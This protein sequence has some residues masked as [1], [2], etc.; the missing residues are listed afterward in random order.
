MFQLWQSQ[1]RNVSLQQNIRLLSVT[2]FSYMSLIPL[3]PVGP[4]GDRGLTGMNG[5]KGASGPSGPQGN[6]CI[7]YHCYYCFFRFMSVQT[8]N[9]YTF[10]SWC[11]CKW[12]TC[13][14]CACVPVCIYDCVAIQLLIKDILP[15]NAISYVTSH[16]P[17]HYTDTRLTSTVT[18]CIKWI[19]QPIF[20]WNISKRSW[21][22]V[23]WNIHSRQIQ[24]SR[25]GGC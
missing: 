23:I 8:F 11:A 15:Q 7:S 13:K 20:W 3:G 25:Q 19:R 6:M 18:T 22:L 14:W 9:L 24:T 12:C 1:C 17:S 10:T 16:H 2:L 5:L 21:Y 4:K